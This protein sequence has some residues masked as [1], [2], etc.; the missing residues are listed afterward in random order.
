MLAAFL[1]MI[2]SA[3][4]IFNSARLVRYGEHLQTAPLAPSRPA[5]EPRKIAPKPQPVAAPA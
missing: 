1:H 2:A 4:V 5:P 3:I